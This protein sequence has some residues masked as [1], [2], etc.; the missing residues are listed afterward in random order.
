MVQT[1]KSH[2]S[3]N[4]SISECLLHM[5]PVKPVAESNDFNLIAFCFHIGLIQ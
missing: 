1:V 3:F 4:N 2:L 5:Q